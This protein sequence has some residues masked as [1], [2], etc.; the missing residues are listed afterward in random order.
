MECYYSRN[1]EIVGY[2]ERIHVI[3]KERGMFYV[4]EQQFLD[5]KWEVI[6]KKWFSDLE[7]NQIK[8]KSFGVTE[9]SDEYGCKGPVRFG[10]EDNVV[11]ENQCHVVLE[12]NCLNQHRYSNCNK[13][14]THNHLVHKRTLNLLAKLAYV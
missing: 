10:E 7:L 4:K 13:T 3:W 12:H 5:Q 6:T 14:R 9:Y 8:E 1:L 11:C 2:I